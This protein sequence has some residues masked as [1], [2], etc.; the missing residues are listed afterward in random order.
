MREGW[1]IVDQL[2]QQ[3]VERFCIAPGSRSSS[4]ALA[5]AEHPKV[6]TIVHFDERGVGF[7]ALGYGKGSGKPAAIITTSG[8]AAGNLLPAVMEARYSGTPLI[9]LSADRPHELRE[10]GANQTAD[11]TKM[12]QNFADW[13]FDLAAGLEEKTVRSIAVQAVFHA[14]QGGPVQLNC[15]FREPY[16][17]YPPFSQGR[18][19]PISLPKKIG[20]P[21]RKKASRGVILLGRCADPRPVLALAKRLRWPVFAD[22]LSNARCTPTEE[23]IRRFDYLIRSETA[24]PDLLLHFGDRFTSKHILDWAKEAPLLHVSPRTNLIDPAR[25][26]AERIQSDVEPFCEGF[27]ADTDP[28]WLPEWQEIDRELGA[29]IDERFQSPP[30]EAHAFR[31]LPH[32]RPLYLGAS[33][34]IR[35]ADHFFFPPSHPGFFSNRG[36]SGIDGNIATASGIAGVLDRPII[37]FIGDQAALHDLNSLP[38]LKKKNVLLIVSNNFGGGI[39]DYL[40]VSSSPRLDAYFTASHSWHFESA[41]EMFG[42]PYLRCEKSLPALPEWGVVELVTDRKENRAFQKELIQACS[43]ALT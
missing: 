39:F 34:P 4:L 26:L 1:W 11:Q 41:A 35:D 7:Y 25:R 13:Q 10:C 9:V 27:E 38:L 29:I 40:P 42:I 2:A 43:L 18:P 3:G 16:K 23:Q 6:E 21:V 12:F 17:E 8:T 36:L 30:V 14:L 31:S 24:K 37:A 5:A 19:V 20:D 28:D 15:P 33:M 32:D 22:L